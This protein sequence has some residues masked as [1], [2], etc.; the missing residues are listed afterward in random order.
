MAKIM[1]TTS[2]DTPINHVDRPLFVTNDAV[3]VAM[4]IISTAPGQN[5]RS[6]GAGPS[7]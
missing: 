2:T 3:I 1:Y 6:I 4:S 7:T 5:C